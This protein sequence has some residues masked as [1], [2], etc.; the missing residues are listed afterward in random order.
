MATL[1]GTAAATALAPP[2]CG[3]RSGA[4]FAGVGGRRMERQLSGSVAASSGRG[5]E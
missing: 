3:A 2:S 4:R 5:W 1:G